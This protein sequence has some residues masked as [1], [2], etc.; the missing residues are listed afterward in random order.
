MKKT[1]D[2]SIQL[3][4]RD[5]DDE[6]KIKKPMET[7]PYHNPYN[8]KE[9]SSTKY[10]RKFLESAQLGKLEV[11][12]YCI[13]KKVN[14]NATNSFNY[15]AIMM[16]AE[17]G[18]FEMVKYLVEVGANITSN[19]YGALR[20]A[21]LQDRCDI[22]KYL[23]ELGCDANVLND[24]N[25]IN[26]TTKEVIDKYKSSKELNERLINTLENTKKSFIKVKI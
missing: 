19:N 24:L 22:V 12:Q 1:L 9:I 4:I 3:T 16:A 6:H 25:N 18:Q 23:L 21:V 7:L 11:V 14:I 17:M 20:L 13:K 15:T 8:Q 26:S 5:T 2:D 10:D